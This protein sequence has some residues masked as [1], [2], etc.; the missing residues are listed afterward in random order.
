M[1]YRDM[2]FE[3]VE[4]DMYAKFRKEQEKKEDLDLSDLGDGEY[5]KAMAAAGVYIPKERNIEMSKEEVD[6]EF[7]MELA[8]L[9]DAGYDDFLDKMKNNKVKLI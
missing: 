2:V 3:Y 7:A 1:K 6:A 8:P 9:D 4:H 5:E